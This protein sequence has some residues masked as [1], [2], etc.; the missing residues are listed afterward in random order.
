MTE[1]IV[2]QETKGTPRNKKGKDKEAI[3]NRR[4]VG[5]F[6]VKESLSAYMI[7]IYS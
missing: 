3:I 7:H 6:E 2:E 1:P 4:T 5:S